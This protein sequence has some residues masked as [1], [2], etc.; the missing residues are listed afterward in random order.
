[1]KYIN[2]AAL[3]LGLWVASGAGLDAAVLK[4]AVSLPPQA[5]IVRAVG[6]ERVEV[7]V[8]LP[9]GVGHESYS[10]RLRMLRRVAMVDLYWA[11]GGGFRT[12]LAS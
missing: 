10:P 7:T 1:M 2:K 9:A 11:T 4:V 6:G 5:E 12:D 8:V 3:I